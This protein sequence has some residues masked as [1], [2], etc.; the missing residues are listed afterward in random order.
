MVV[1]ASEEAAAW[2]SAHIDSPQSREK[3]HQK[4]EPKKYFSYSERLHD[5]MCDI[6]AADV[7]L[8]SHDIIQLLQI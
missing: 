8:M 7:E 2:S 5:Y 1:S 6:K 3:K 4:R